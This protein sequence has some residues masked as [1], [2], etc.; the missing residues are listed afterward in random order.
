VGGQA[1]EHAPVGRRDTERGRVVE[2][3]YFDGCPN[4]EETRALVGAL[5][6]ELELTPRIE[7]VQV[8]DAEAAA[9]LRF[10]GSPTVRVD[11]QDVEPGAGRRSEF[12]LCCRVYRT[13]NGFQGQPDPDWIRSGLARGGTPST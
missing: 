11:G 12:A 10:L 13:A 9:R 4:Y 6:A 5:A 7:L 1:R 2:I 8:P 3:L